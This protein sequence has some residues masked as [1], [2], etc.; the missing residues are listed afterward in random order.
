MKMMSCHKDARRQGLRIGLSSLIAIVHAPRDKALARPTPATH[1]LLVRVQASPPP[2]PRSE[3]RPALPPADMAAPYPVCEEVEPQAAAIEEVETRLS[4]SKPVDLSAFSWLQ[5][6]PPADSKCGQ[7][8]S[9]CFPGA[10]PG[11]AVVARMKVL[12]KLYGALPPGLLAGVSLS[13]T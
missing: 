3:T 12:E 8:L 13:T 7:A 1:W 4:K 6:S 2:A 10:L 5:W 9:R 11:P